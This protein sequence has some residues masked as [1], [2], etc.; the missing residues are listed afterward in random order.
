MKL[1][2]GILLILFG[3]YLIIHVGG[4]LGVVGGVATMLDAIKEYPTSPAMLARGLLK[5]LGGIVLCGFSGTC[6]IIPGC[7]MVAVSKN[8]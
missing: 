1:T 7:Y 6:I 5:I 2:F 3:L 4:Y 8:K